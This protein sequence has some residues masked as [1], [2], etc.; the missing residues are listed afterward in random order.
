MDDKPRHFEKYQDFLKNR[1]I[2]N[3]NKLL[4]DNNQN[5]Y[6]YKGNN[7]STNNKTEPTFNLNIKNI[8]KNN[9]TDSGCLSSLRRQFNSK[10]KVTTN[11]NLET[12]YKTFYTND[13]PSKIINN[14]NNKN[15][16]KYKYKR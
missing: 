5:N 6:Y 13:S 2:Y 10:G 16:K 14:K 8:E 7:L 1:K 9:E 11:Q 3:N 15:N 4:E 12:N